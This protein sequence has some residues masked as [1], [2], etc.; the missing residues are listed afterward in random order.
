MTPLRTKLVR[1]SLI[2]LGAVGLAVVLVTVIPAAA[3]LTEEPHGELE[4][5]SNGRWES[6]GRLLVANQA[7][8]MRA[9][10]AGNGFAGRAAS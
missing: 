4:S 3:H 6:K 2:T 8:A 9:F 10:V 5:I 1:T 7:V